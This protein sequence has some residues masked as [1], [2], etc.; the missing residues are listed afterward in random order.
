V[1][2]CVWLGRYD[3]ARESKARRAKAEAKRLEL[4]VREHGVAG[5][6]PESIE[7]S[8]QAIALDPSSYSLY[9]DL[10]YTLMQVTKQPQHEQL[11]IKQRLADAKSG[12][13]D[14]IPFV[15]ALTAAYS[16]TSAS[17][18]ARAIHVAQVGV[19]VGCAVLARSAQAV[20]VRGGD[21][22]WMGPALD[23]L[24]QE[25]VSKPPAA[26]VQNCVGALSR[27]ASS[28]DGLDPLASFVA[29]R[30]ALAFEKKYGHVPGYP[31][32]FNW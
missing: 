11:T 17:L 32:L 19:E 2:R 3:T 6:Y 18:Q 29:G 13:D 23:A 25:A 5:R 20:F 14:K 26:H 16:P 30:L 8:L 4:A 7:A 9:A 12:G 10:S 28:A 31:E 22:A 1:Y 21:Y 24:S 27:V 15:P